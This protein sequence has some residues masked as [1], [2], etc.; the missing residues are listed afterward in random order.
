[1]LYQRVTDMMLLVQG[2]GFE[3]A[4][5]G[6]AHLDAWHMFSLNYCYV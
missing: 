2:I 5:D 1:M 6:I 3:A 4:I